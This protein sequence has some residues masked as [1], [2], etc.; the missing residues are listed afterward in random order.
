MGIKNP[1]P[2][3]ENYSLNN[4][5]VK[6][7]ASYDEVRGNQYLTCDAFRVNFGGGF[8]YGYDQIGEVK[9]C[10]QSFIPRDGE[11]FVLSN[12]DIEVEELVHEGE[13]EEAYINI[14]P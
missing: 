1:N 10:G 8:N 6:V 7:T 9:V 14:K 4:V 11:R 12:V 5:M 2:E 13:V 3:Q